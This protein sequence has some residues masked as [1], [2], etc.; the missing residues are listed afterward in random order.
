MPDA[1]L[2]LF[3]DAF[4]ISPYAFSVFVALEEKGLPYAVETVALHEKAQRQPAFRDASITGKVPALRHGDFWLSESSAIVE[5]LDDVFPAP[6]HPTALPAGA[7]DR[8]RA[9]QIMAWIRSDL[10][11]IREQ[12]PTWSMFY[13]PT[14]RPLDEAGEAAAR[15]LLHTA[16][17]LLPEGRTTLFASGFSVADADLAFMLQRL[18]GNGDHVPSRLRAFAE[19]QW[20]RP[21]VRKFVTRPRP[22]YVPY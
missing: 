16:D 1:P 5:Y 12:R 9:R 13:Q 19:A 18:L 11:P 7:R 15:R 4:W 2:T 6:A 14:G 21:S 17:L 8:G 20:Q 22:A 10:L 3:T